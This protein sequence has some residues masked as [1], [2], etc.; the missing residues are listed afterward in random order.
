MAQ[1][2]GYIYSV[3]LVHLKLANIVYPDKLQII[4][5]LR[6]FYHDE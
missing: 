2:C 6:G 4:F 1:F 3:H 5:S